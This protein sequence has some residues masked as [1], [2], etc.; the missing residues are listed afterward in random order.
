MEDPIELLKIYINF[1]NNIKTSIKSNKSK[2]IPCVIVT[3]EDLVNW[4]NFYEYSKDLKDLI[5]DKFLLSEWS[6]RIKSKNHL[7][8]PIFHILKDY[9]EI[10]THL[11][12][13]KGISLLSKD[14][15]N[16]FQSS[17]KRLNQVNCYF[18]KDK[19]ILKLYSIEYSDCLICKIGSKSSSQYIIYEIITP[20]NA[21]IIDDI[22]KKTSNLTKK[23]SFPNYNINKILNYKCDKKQ[24]C[25]QN[26]SNY[27]KDNSINKDL[28][29][30]NKIKCEGNISSLMNIINQEECN[31]PDCIFEF[32]VL[33]HKF[34]K[35]IKIKINEKNK[36]SEEYYLVNSELIGNLK[37]N[38]NYSEI[39]KELEKI[40]YKDN[41]DFENKINDTI[42]IIKHKNIINEVVPFDNIDIEPKKKYI[43]SRNHYIDFCIVNK[44]IFNAIEKIKIYFGSKKSSAPNKCWFYFKPQL[45]YKGKNFIKIGALNED[46]IFVIHYFIS[47]DLYNSIFYNILYEINNSKSVKDFFKK[48]NT[49][50]FDLIN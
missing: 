28:L 34:N 38:Y 15:I 22:L 1:R 47:L 33:L 2:I 12:K 13:N 14:F 30:L 19:I 9:N 23:S 16:N 32:F 35:D 4:K 36:T 37:V 46:Y 6:S 39:S 10:K 45:F 48:K 21:T 17:N 41:Y 3:K 50:K 31:I 18:G 40:K 24:I 43:Y 42:N 20:Y 7:K 8:K 27:D 25:S 11:S 5:S 29:K 49:N 26:C 44:N